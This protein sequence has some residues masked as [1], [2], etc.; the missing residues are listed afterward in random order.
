MIYNLYVNIE[1][2]LVFWFDKALDG[3]SEGQQK[4]SSPA[5]T[6]FRGT[7]LWRIE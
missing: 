3:N 4:S 6:G 2:L 5:M 1:V 7:I